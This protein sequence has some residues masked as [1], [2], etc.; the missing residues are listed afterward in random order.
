M[1]SEPESAFANDF[2]VLAHLRGYPEDLHR[3]ANLMKQ[4][5]PHGISAVEFLLKRPPSP[6]G[7]LEALCRFV[8]DRVNILTG[9][10]VA[11]R[12]QRTPAAFLD[13]LA[14]RPDFPKPLFRKG[15]R[16]LWRAQDI[17]AYLARGGA[18]AG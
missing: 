16:G 12:L 17:D 4:A 8:Q 14:G 9:V 10:E 18:I 7:F 1:G 3:Y 13:D 6:D 2:T 11:A 15:H 5:H